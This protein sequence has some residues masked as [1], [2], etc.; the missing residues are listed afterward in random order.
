MTA[1]PS[2]HR[3]PVYESGE[4]LGLSSSTGTCLPWRLL[5]AARSALWLACAMLR[6]PSRAPASL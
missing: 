4:F 3:S 1:L 5:A 2:Q 6:M